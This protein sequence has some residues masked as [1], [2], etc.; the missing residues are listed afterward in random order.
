MDAIRDSFPRI[1]DKKIEAKW[2]KIISDSAEGNSSGG[3]FEDRRSL[4]TE[5]DSAYS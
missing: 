3:S 5:E 2:Q 1:S 4:L